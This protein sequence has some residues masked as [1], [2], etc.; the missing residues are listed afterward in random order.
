[1]ELFISPA[2]TYRNRRTSREV[3]FLHRP[4]AYQVARFLMAYAAS[5]SSS[6]EVLSWRS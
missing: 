4:S 5:V 6:C 1:M 2:S 3:L